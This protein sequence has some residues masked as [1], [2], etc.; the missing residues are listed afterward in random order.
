MEPKA[1]Q[2]HK[3]IKDYYGTIAE[4]AETSCC[5][6]QEPCC[7]E[8]KQ[9]VPYYDLAMLEGAPDEAAAM[10][11]GC[12]DPVTLASLRPGEVVLDLGSGGGLDCFL[13][14]KAVGEE[15]LVIGVDMTE[16]MLEKANASKAK[17]GMENVD[18][19]FGQIEDL[20]VESNR[21]DVV[22]SNC[23]INLAPDKRAVFQEAFRVLRPGG[24][25]SVSDIV[26]EG[27][28]SPEARSDLLSWAGCVAGAI[29]VEDYLAKLRDAGFV[30]VE[31]VDS[32]EAG[33]PV[34]GPRL[35]SARVS[36]RKP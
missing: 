32:V 4:S 28:F 16:A 24:R 2:I 12:G 25:I 6:P 9:T 3:A 29:D 1:K 7:G 34:D 14:A 22:M 20:P 31:L 13:A 23:V 33:T 10:S 36:G 17:L 21:V 26:T 35:F 30:E 19:R 11:L 8:S 5:E 18:F 27:E 15:G